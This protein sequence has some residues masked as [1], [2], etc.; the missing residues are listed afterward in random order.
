M[1]SVV[2]SFIGA[3][4]I[5]LTSGRNNV[6]PASTRPVSKMASIRF[7]AGDYAS[8]SEANRANHCSSV[9]LKLPEL[10]AHPNVGQGHAH[11]GECSK[12]DCDLFMIVRDIL[13]SCGMCAT[14]IRYQAPVR[15]LNRWIGVPCPNAGAGVVTRSPISKVR[16]SCCAAVCTN[17]RGARQASEGNLRTAKHSYSTETINLLKP[18]S[19]LLRLRA[20]C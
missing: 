8:L 10:F 20:S 15:N 17:H 6:L 13:Q 1:A 14:C 5:A 9:A 7:G 12:G 11:P 18:R 16:R 3:R 2:C 19:T 4:L